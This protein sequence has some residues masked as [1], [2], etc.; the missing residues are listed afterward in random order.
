MGLVVQ[1]PVD[2]LLPVADPVTAPSGPPQDEAETGDV[3]A[4]L[5]ASLSAGP[6]GTAAEL[7]VGELPSEGATKATRRTKRIRLPHSWR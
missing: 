3:F 6:E 4:N 1:S 7:P 2:A 5:L